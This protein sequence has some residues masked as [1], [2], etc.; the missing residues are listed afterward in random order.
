MNAMKLLLAFTTTLSIAS[1][2]MTDQE[3]DVQFCDVNNF[4][5]IHTNYRNNTLVF[6]RN[7]TINVTVYYHKWTA[8]YKKLIH[9]ISNLEYSHSGNDQHNYHRN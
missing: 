5:I 9:N 4:Y 6:M 8:D 2:V 3:N 7:T 1:V